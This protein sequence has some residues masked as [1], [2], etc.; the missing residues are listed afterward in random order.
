MPQY[1]ATATLTIEP[2]PA[3]LQE[4]AVTRGRALRLGADGALYVSRGYNVLQSKDEGLTWTLRAGM[5][6]Q[7]IRRVA[8]LSRMAARLLR[9]EVKAFDE[10]RSGGC[11]AANREGVYFARSGERA[12][13][14]SAVEAAGQPV[15][16]PMTLTVGPNDRILWG[17]YN[18]KTD[19]GLPVRLYVSDDGGASYSIARVFEGGS[20]L[21]IHNLI[22]DA[23]L[24]CYWVLSGDHGQ[25]PGIGRLS[26]DL[27]DFDW[28]AKG[29]QRYRAVEVFDLGDTLV[30]ATDT[31]R[32]QNALMAFDKASGRF[33]RGRE[34]HGSCIYAC[35]FG[36]I[37]AMTTT[38]EPSPVNASRSARLLVSRNAHDWTA[39]LSAE[40]DWWNPVYFQFGSIVLPRGTGP[41]ETILYSGQAVK[42]LDDRAVVAT[43]DGDVL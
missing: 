42:G 43:L 15:K 21:H 10:L 30:Y 29:E 2:A 24:D 13:R 14:A 36:G 38:V 1:R 26:A 6:E 19:H 3:S 33:E 20:I 11:V 7:G 40:K 4:R 31:E 5:P 17:E 18:S 39:V 12:M 41:R 16:P 22:Y 37:F 25:Q 34:F 9:H 28:I 35:R 8:R 23:R 27:K 32:E